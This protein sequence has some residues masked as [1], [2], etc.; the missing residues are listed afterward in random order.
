MSSQDSHGLY[1]SLQGMGYDRESY[2]GSDVGGM[3]ASGYG[4]DYMPHGS[5]VG[6]Y[7]IY[8]FQ[9]CYFSHPKKSCLCNVQP[10]IVSSIQFDSYTSSVWST[11]NSLSK[12]I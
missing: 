5:D 11:L 3:Y 7:F 6:F 2:S 4:G 8:P 1:S 12:W 10:F 9:A